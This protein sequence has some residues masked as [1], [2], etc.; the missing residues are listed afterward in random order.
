MR[1]GKEEK[2]YERRRVG[3]KMRT[4]AKDLTIGQRRR[5]QAICIW[6]Y[7]SACES[8]KICETWESMQE[9][10]KATKGK[11]RYKKKKTRDVSMYKTKTQKTKHA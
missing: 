1:E 2:A 10:R 8:W 9:R 11:G 3:G 4:Q 7:L 5:V 6:K